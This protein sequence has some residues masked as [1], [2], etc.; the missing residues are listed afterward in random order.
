MKIVSNLSCRTSVI[1]KYFCPCLCN[2]CT[3]SV[4]W[5]QIQVIGLKYSQGGS[6]I[7]YKIHI[8]AK[9]CILIS[10]CIAFIISSHFIIVLIGCW[11]FS[12]SSV[13][14]TVWIQ[15]NI[16]VG[17]NLGP[18]C[19]QRLS[20]D[21]KSRPYSGQRVKWKIVTVLASELTL[22]SFK[23]DPRDRHHFYPA[24]QFWEIFIYSRASF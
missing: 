15:I 7:T 24:N 11:I 19:L 14:K 22:L 4:E 17:P 1:L 5:L 20:A 2:P 13:C 18:N 10:L 21:N 9:M 23:R 12:T 6:K 8:F 3:K 16:F